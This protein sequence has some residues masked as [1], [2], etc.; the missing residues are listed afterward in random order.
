MNADI[1][2]A[3]AR[4]EKAEAARLE[5]V[6]EELEARAALIS[7]GFPSPTYGTNKTALGDGR[8]LKATYTRYYKLEN[9][10]KLQAALKVLPSAIRDNLVKY[11]PEI[12]V[13]AYN[14]LEPAHKAVINEVL[15]ITTGRPSVEIVTPKPS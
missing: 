10:P 6:S 11:K 4:W 9:G 12:S 15:T 2:A 8:E 13:S 7:L 5:A 14:A 1:A 3:I